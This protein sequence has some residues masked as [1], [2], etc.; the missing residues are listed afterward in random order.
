M[1]VHDRPGC[2]KLTV[3]CSA[4]TQRARARLNSTFRSG[5]ERFDLSGSC[6]LPATVAWSACRKLTSCWPLSR[7]IVAPAR[8][9]ASASRPVNLDVLSLL[10]WS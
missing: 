4:A 9:P 6:R 5:E 3:T 1:G 10:K 2:T 8:S 7:R